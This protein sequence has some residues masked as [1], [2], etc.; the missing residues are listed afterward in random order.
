M[1]Q[2]GFLLEYGPIPEE[3]LE[4]GQH[5]GAAAGTQPTPHTTT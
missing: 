2:S 1:Q 4:A 5:G 3:D